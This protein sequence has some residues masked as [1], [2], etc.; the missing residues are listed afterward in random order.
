MH[1]S[2]SVRDSGPKK[3]FDGKNGFL[4]IYYFLLTEGVDAC[5]ISIVVSTAA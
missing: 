3:D 2:L 5:I 4:M 1:E